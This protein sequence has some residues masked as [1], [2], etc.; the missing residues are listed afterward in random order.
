VA[1]SEHAVR[2][3]GEL[4][5]DEIRFECSNE[6]GALPLPLAGEGRGGGVSASGLLRIAEEVPARREPSPAALCERVGLSRKR[7]RP[8]KPAGQSIQ[9]KAIPL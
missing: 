2:R 3:G 6:G 9:L 4:E 7:E 1:G 8:S 5:R